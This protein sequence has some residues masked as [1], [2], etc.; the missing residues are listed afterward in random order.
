[1]YDNKGE[2]I[3][4]NNMS[5]KVKMVVMVLM[6]ALVIF[7]LLA[8]SSVGSYKKLTGLDKIGEAT[9]LATK[10]SAM[11]HNTQKERGASAGFIGS[12]GSKFKEALT[13]IRKD[14]DATRAEM[15]AYEC[16]LFRYYR[17]YCKDE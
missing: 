5:I 1:M 10:I 2:I 12:K 6:P 8:M 11:I 16:C 13:K 9:I 14:T 3:M 7:V 15:Q 17:S 4:L